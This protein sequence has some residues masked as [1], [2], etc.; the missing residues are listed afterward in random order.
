LL[1]KKTCYLGQFEE[2]YRGATDTP[3]GSSTSLGMAGASIYVPI[4]PTGLTD[5]ITGQ[6]YVWPAVFTEWA[7][8]TALYDQ[9]KICGVK[10]R[11][12]PSVDGYML[13]KSHNT[14][15]Y[16][17]AP[18]LG[19]V[20]SFLDYNSV[21]P[22][23]QYGT[24]SSSTSTIIAN[25]EQI[26]LNYRN[27]K[28]TR[29]DQVHKRYFRPSYSITN[30]QILGIPAGSLPVTIAF[31]GWHS[32]NSQTSFFGCNFTTGV[33]YCASTYTNPTVLKSWKIYMTMYVKFKQAR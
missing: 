26:A 12:E 4:A 14:G 8:Y 31:K 9:Y 18:G 1:A 21:N 23:V 28:T 29:S 17:G 3:V 20:H 2:V 11:L 22:S 13:D 7:S 19:L 30:S 33:D 24:A 6:G 25:N 16:I 10:I 15:D 5:T 32:T 27:L